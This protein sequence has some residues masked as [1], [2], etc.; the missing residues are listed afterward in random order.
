MRKSGLI[1]LLLF[2]FTQLSFAQNKIAKDVSVK[3]FSKLITTGKGTLLD[4]RTPGEIA[5][6]SIKG[7]VN[8]DFF[9][10]NFESKLDQLDKTK[11]VYVYC[12]SGGR[13]S[14]AMDMM[15]KQ[16]FVAV[17]NLLGGYNAWVKEFG[18]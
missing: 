8:M 17:Y 9:D 13:S 7:S 12:A 6:G 4:V 3:E 10:D 14:D 15:K 11:P 18:K 5:K 16:G 2:F 1:A